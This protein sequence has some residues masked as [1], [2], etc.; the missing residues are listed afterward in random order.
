QAER[1]NS[2]ARW[3]RGIGYVTIL[4][5][6]LFAS[7]IVN[8]LL[9]RKVSK[10]RTVISAMQSEGRLQPGAAL[11]AL[12]GFSIDGKPQSLNYADVRVP[13]VLYVFTP[14]CGWCAK[15][16]ENFRALIQSS[17]PRYRIIGVSLTRQDLKEYLQKENLQLPIY[18]DVEESSRKTYKLGGT[19]AT[20]V[21]SP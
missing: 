11:P 21:M 14:Q 5:V 20:V 9:A 2:S 19:P 6:L 16:I 3:G 17:G 15:N 4:T 1:T 12:Q 13:T 10:L 8:C 7:V 18:T